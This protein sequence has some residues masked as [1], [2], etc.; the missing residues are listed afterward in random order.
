MLEKIESGFSV[1]IFPEG[2][3]SGGSG[4]LPFKKGGFKLAASSNIPVVPVALVFADERDFWIG[5]ETFLSHA[6]KRFAEKEI[7]VKLIYGSA[8][9]SDDPELLISE[10]NHWINAALTHYKS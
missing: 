9:K 10:T 2:T 5:K 8:I 3:T 6:R 1:I 7:K 4:T